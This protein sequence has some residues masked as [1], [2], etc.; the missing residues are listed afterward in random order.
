MEFSAARQPTGNIS[1]CNSARWVG[2]WAAKYRAAAIRMVPALVAIAPLAK[3]PHARLE[4]LIGVKAGI[5][6]EESVRQRRDQRFGWVTEDQMAGNKASRSTDLLLA[7]K[8][9]EQRGADFL[10]AT[11]R[12]SA[13]SRGPAGCESAPNRDPARDWSYHIESM[14]IISVLVGSPSAP[15]GTPCHWILGHRIKVVTHAGAGSR[16]GADSQTPF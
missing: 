9:V 8:C 13:P 11:G 4:H 16:F 7:I 5:L 2:K 12:P 15:I 10:G 14:P 1:V 6:T 3:L